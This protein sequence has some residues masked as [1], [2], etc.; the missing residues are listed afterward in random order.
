MEELKKN[1]EY[2]EKI[3][4]KAF[5]REKCEIFVK[6]GLWSIVDQLGNDNVT[7]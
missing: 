5:I 6:E 2:L 7:E 4:L 3:Y 1:L